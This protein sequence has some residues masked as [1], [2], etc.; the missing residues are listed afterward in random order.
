MVTY[1]ES[2]GKSSSNT[3]EEFSKLKWGGESSYTHCTKVKL[4]AT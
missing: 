1:L 2:G 3:I 4:K